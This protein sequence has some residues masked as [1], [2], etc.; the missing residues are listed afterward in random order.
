MAESDKSLVTP[1]VVECISRS[2]LV[3][4]NKKAYQQLCRAPD[5]LIQFKKTLGR[6]A[7]FIGP[8]MTTFKMTNFSNAIRSQRVKVSDTSVH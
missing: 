8:I 7:R 6:K 4:I 5:S 3:R 2:E 1:L